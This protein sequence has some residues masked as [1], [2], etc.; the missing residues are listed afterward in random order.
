MGEDYEA[1]QVSCH[2]DAKIWIGLRLGLLAKER[3]T[4]VWINGLFVRRRTI[5]S[6]THL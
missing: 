4:E 5:I 1:T 2:V 6:S 3:W